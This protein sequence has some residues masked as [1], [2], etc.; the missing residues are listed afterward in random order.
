MAV[1]TGREN[2]APLSIEGAGA[3]AVCADTQVAARKMAA[4]EATTKALKLL[5]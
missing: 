4:I 5:I 1:D 3:A 2:P